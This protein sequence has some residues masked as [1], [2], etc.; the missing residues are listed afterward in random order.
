[1]EQGLK[2]AGPRSR[3]AVKPVVIIALAVGAIVGIVVVKGMVGAVSAYA[4]EER[5]R[6]AIG[7]IARSLSEP[8]A[9]A[10]D[11]G[12]APVGKLGVADWETGDVE[13]HFVSKIPPAIRASGPEDLGTLLLIDRQKVKV[14]SYI[15]EA[16]GEPTG[17]AFRWVW[18][19]RLVDVASSTVIARR[20]FVG[21][22]PP[23]TTSLDWNWGADPVD[24]TMAWAVDKVR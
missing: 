4:A 2:S 6:D 13:F 22:E 19:A 7:A 12:A 18:D 15:D 16:T 24:E 20:E 21:E 23:E 5:G 11:L 9:L 14:G 3:G 10:E 17:D 1:M 8:G